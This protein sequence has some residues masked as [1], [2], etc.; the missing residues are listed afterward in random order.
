MSPNLSLSLSLQ[1]SDLVPLYW[2]SIQSSSVLSL[3][4]VQL[5]ATAARQASMSITNSQSLSKWLTLCSNI[6]GLGTA[7][8]ASSQAHIQWELSFPL[9]SNPQIPRFL[10][11][12]VAHHSPT[13]TQSLW[14]EN[15]NRLLVGRNESE[16]SNTAQIRNPADS[17]LFFFSGMWR[18]MGGVMIF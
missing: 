5:F 11:L 9:S 7:K 17:Q 1:F 16:L 10:P 2:L 15:P 3:S 12:G 18:K 13:L 14:S 8:V 4:Y 6:S